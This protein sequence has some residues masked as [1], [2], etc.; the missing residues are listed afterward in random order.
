M[1]IVN[2]IVGGCILKGELC[3]DG[4]FYDVVGDSYYFDDV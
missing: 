2:F 4:L 1:K 3:Q